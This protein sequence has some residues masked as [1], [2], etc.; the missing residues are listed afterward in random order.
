MYSAKIGGL[1][2]K[3]MRESEEKRAPSCL[4]YYH[5]TTLGNKAFL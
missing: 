3:D 2:I 4:G 1:I 5:C